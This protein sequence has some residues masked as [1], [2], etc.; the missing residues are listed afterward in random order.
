[1]IGDVGC[2]FDLTSVH[3]FDDVIS[4]VLGERER[5]QTARLEQVE[6]PLHSRL[7]VSNTLLLASL[8]VL[9]VVLRYEP[10]SQHNVYALEETTKIRS[11][12]SPT[13]IYINGSLHIISIV[14]SCDG[15]HE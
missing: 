7:E 3:E 8:H 9:G 10:F 14:Q 15:K 6:E 5:V 1:M 12:N 11:L 13:I 4:V 2:T